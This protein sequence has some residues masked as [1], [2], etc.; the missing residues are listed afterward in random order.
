MDEHPVGV[1]ATRRRLSSF[2]LGV[3]ERR[4][5]EGGAKGMKE[6]V[7]AEGDFLAFL[8]VGR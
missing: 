1:F 2:P 3:Y 5:E 4:K 6:R 7:G 8:K